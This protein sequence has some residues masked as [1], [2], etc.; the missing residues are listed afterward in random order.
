MAESEGGVTDDSR[1]SVA[2]DKE[3]DRIAQEM[4]D[5]VRRMQAL[6]LRESELDANASE[7]PELYA[8]LA[9]RRRAER[10]AEISEAGLPT[11]LGPQDPVASLRDNMRNTQSA[12]ATGT[13]RNE[14]PRS[15]SRTPPQASLP[16]SSAG[17]ESVVA[18]VTGEVFE[19]AGPKEK[20]KDQD[21]ERMRK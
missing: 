6:S 9:S 21:K 15:V 14:I 5:L 17:A 12:T 7:I 20:K 2:M 18:L 16:A 1:Q 13:V 19:P 10:R 4:L 3:L 11:S 8:E